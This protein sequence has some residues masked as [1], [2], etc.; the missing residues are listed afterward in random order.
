[1]QA[2]DNSSKSVEALLSLSPM[3]NVGISVF[4]FWGP[5]GARGQSDADRVQVGGIFDVQVTDQLEL[6]LEGYYGNQANVDPMD[7]PGVNARW[8]G[9]AGYFIYDFTDQWGLRVRGEVFED[10]AG[11]FACGGHDRL[12]KNRIELED[13]DE[14]IGS[15][16]NALVCTKEG[17]DADN[18]ILGETTWTLQYTPVP[19]LITRLEFRYDK[20]N[21]DTFRDG[22]GVGNNQTT[23][24]AE[25]IFLF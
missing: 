21:R 14:T 13:G 22:V 19:N 8:N 16:G 20:S 18:L 1:M 9:V 17:F 15:L 24:A 12:D 3:E 11:S 5:E 23:L 10:A 4:G 25:A 7:R 6:V 2:D